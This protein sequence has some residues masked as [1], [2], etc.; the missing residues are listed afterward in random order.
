ML[1][2]VNLPAVTS[3]FKKSCSIF[4]KRWVPFILNN[5]VFPE[6]WSYETMNSPFEYDV[7]AL[8]VWIW[9]NSG[10][11]KGK[12]LESIKKKLFLNNF[13]LTQIDEENIK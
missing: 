3:S 4:E 6:S 8:T 9:N 10:F 2:K 1:I 5:W 12:K 13:R 11:K 7:S